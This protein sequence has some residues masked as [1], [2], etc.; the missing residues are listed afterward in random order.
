MGS[1]GALDPHSIQHPELNDGIRE[2]FREHRV[3]HFFA[4]E[5]TGGVGLEPCHG[6]ETAQTVSATGHHFGAIW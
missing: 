4:T 1:E 2:S 3:T 6:A 5:W